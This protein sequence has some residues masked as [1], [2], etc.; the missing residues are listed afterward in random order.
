[1][2]GVCVI[3]ELNDRSEGRTNK[4]YGVHDVRKVPNPYITTKKVPVKEKVL[5]QKPETNNENNKDRIRR[6]KS[7]KF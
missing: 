4:Y 3:C 2:Q 5:Q 1:M 7:G 6:R